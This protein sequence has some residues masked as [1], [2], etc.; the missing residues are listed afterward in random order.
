MYAEETFEIS[1]PNSEATI[2]HFFNKKQ[3]LFLLRQLD[4][5]HA[6]YF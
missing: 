4:N 6:L 2:S 3:Q 1:I 5:I